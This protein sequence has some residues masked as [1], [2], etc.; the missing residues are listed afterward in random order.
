M[1]N[2]GL[3]VHSFMDYF[4]YPTMLLCARIGQ[5]IFTG[6]VARCHSFL[7]LDNIDIMEYINSSLH[8]S[9]PF[10]ESRSRF[11]YSFRSECLTLNRTGDCRRSRTAGRRTIYCLNYAAHCWAMPE[12]YAVWL[13]IW[14]YILILQAFSEAVTLYLKHFATKVYWGPTSTLN[15]LYKNILIS[16]Y[17]SFLASMD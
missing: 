6:L 8:S 17:Y 10:T 2:F 16:R 7:S 15:I 9:H 5:N 1:G 11:P 3:V 13:L 4:D 12:S 14:T